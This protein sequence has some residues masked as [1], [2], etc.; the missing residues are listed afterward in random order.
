MTPRNDFQTVRFERLPNGQGLELPSYGSPGAA[1]LDIRAAEKVIIEPGRIEVVACGFKIEL[2]PGVEAQVRPRSG[3][4]AKGLTVVNAP[5]TIDPDYR[6]E[7]KVILG[8]IGPDLYMVERGERIAQL[9][10][11]P[12]LRLHPL[13]VEALSKTERGEGG[14]G[15]TGRT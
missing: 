15:S 6:G 5:G 7:V 3:L 9:V 14:F 10:F 4:A 2:P 13:E 8:N 1:G 11:A 12:V